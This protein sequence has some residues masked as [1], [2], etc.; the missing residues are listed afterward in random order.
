M[1]YLARGAEY[2]NLLASPAGAG[3]SVPWLIV[4]AHYDAVPGSPGAD[5]NASG[6]AVLLEVARLLVGR[7]PAH[8]RLCAFGT[9][10]VQGT[11]DKGSFAL[12]RAL[13]ER[14]A[15]VGGMLS[16]EMLGYFRETP[17][18]QRFPLPGMGLCYGRRGDFLAVVSDWGAL[19][20]VRRMARTLRRAGG[21]P[22]RSFCGPA[23]MP[24]I[25]WSD[26]ASFRRLGTPAAMLTDTAFHRNPNY[27]RGSDLPA[28]LDY[29]RMAEAA[30]MLA[31]ALSA[32]PSPRA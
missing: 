26:H 15:L 18:S 9:E 14:G 21:V 31:T 19:R 6:V 29:G 2:V 13:R 3:G 23:A 28:T 20:F 25:H 16:L 32:W 30:R 1:P 22:V 11:E 8:L 27:H 12:A 5:D 4:G 17:G 10:E 24:G 7:V